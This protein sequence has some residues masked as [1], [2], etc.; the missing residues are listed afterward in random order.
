MGRF[1][2]TFTAGSL[3]K[4]VVGSVSSTDVVPVLPVSREVHFNALVPGVRLF[5]FR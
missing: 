2:L 4:H 5:V 3:A 1:F